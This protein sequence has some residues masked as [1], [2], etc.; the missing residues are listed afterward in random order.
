MIGQLNGRVIFSD[1]LELILSTSSGIGYQIAFSEQ[2]KEGIEI[3]LFIS[4]IKRE[5]VENLYGFRSFKEKKLFELLNQVK[6]VGPKSAY[7]LIASLGHM[8]IVKAIVGGEKKPLTKAPGIGPRAADQILLDLKAK[9]SK[10]MRLVEEED[11]IE[12][13]QC[14]NLLEEA[15]MALSQ[16]GF[17]EKRAFPL[18]QKIIENQQISSSEELIRLVLKEI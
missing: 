5:N 1:G 14:Q 4:H 8:A 3:S 12:K 11:T 7:S 17:K 18:V 6:G 9:V 2:L 13:G 16:L 15:L 10:I